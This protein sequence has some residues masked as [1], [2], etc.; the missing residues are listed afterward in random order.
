VLAEH[1]EHTPLRGEPFVVW[2]GLGFPL[3]IGLFEDRIEPV[4]HGLVRP[5]DPEIA[6]VVVCGDDIAQEAAQH[7][8]VFRVHC[9]RRW[10]VDRVLAEV[11]HA[12][13]AQQY[14]AVRMGIRAHPTV[15]CWGERG[16]LPV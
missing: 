4:R 10:N 9:T 1:F 16:E 8:R 2:G 7:A 15:A 14:A 3:P 12:K 6:L 5:E 13:L 11:R